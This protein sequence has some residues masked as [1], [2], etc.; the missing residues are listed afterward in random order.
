MT[1]KTYTGFSKRKNSTKQPTGGTDVT[2]TLKE[3]TSIESPVFLLS[4]NDFTINYIKAFDHYY[5]V[6]DIKSVR[7]GLIEISCSMDVLATFKT[8]IGN[9]T[10]F[11]ER[12]DTSTHLN[13][14]LPDPLV[15]S[16]VT[17]R[18]I[19][20]VTSASAVFSSTGCYILSVLNTKGS[21]AGFTSYY[22]LDDTKLEDIANYC[23]SYWGNPTT[24]I[25]EWIQQNLLKTSE[26][27][28]SCIWVP[29]SYAYTTGMSFAHETVEIGV[30]NVT[31]GGTPVEG[32]RFTGGCVAH[33][34]INVVI[35]STGYSDFRRGAPFTQGKLFIPCYGIVDFNPLDFTTGTITCDFDADFATGDV[36]CYLKDG[37]NLISTISY[38]CSANCPVG[39]IGA[40]VEGTA[41][42]FIT[43]LG[44][45]IGMASASTGA[46]A[47]LGA[48]AMTAGGASTIANAI[49]P[50]MSIKGSRGG[51]AAAL[52]GTDVI[53]TL[54]C[55]E[56][57]DPAELLTQ[58]G[59]LV[60]EKHQISSLS[61]YIKCSNASVPIAGMGR[62]KDEVNDYLN[63]GFYYEN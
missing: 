56:T 54:I 49:T 25:L 22:M 42:G 28:V 40:N 11:I 24:T 23:N 63:N 48:L 21:G 58:H 17:E 16:E 44:G 53:C 3:G 7:N 38:N 20:V 41:T 32:W 4:S 61:G 46:G 60:M 37:S 6:E 57:T 52:N 36:M 50:T 14:E 51:R 59:G 27:V 5:F 15:A 55:K 18:V 12:A 8:D 47:A 30:D 34:T 35:P 45:V 39:K 2:C 13:I 19:P 29:F 26:A 62:E 1:I 43:T 33:E 9:Y 31:L 10:A